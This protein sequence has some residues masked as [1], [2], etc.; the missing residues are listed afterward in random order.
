M[1]AHADAAARR[2]FHLNAVEGALFIAGSSCISAQTVLPALVT[3]LG[4][5]NVAVGAI[6]VIMY[7]GLFLPQLFAARYAQTLPW[8]KPWAIGFGAVQRVLILLMGISLTFAA[9]GGSTGMLATFMI[10]FTLMQVATGICTPGWF[11]LFTKLTPVSR[12]G[13]L[14]GLRTSI[15]GLGGLLC[16]TLL[17][18][19]LSVWPFPWSYAGAFLLASV[20]QG[21]SLILQMGLREEAESPVMPRLGLGAYRRQLTTVLGS[22]PGFRRFL[23]SSVF[24]VLAALPMGFYTVYALRHFGASEAAVGE[25]TLLLVAVQVGSALVNGYVADHH[26]NRV[27][28]LLAAS[29]ML[30]ANIWALVAP[31]LAAF[32]LVFVFAGV[33]LGSDL[34]ARYNMSVE[35]GPVEQRSTYVG[36]MNTVLAPVYLLGLAGG[37]LI[38]RFGYELIFLLGICAALA[39]IVLFVWRVHDPRHHAAAIPV[40]RPEMP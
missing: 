28:V 22:N 31:T 3:R 34:M 33:S 8:K 15:G 13:R 10:L 18:V 20:L 6:G 2:N 36:L 26:G 7:V 25:F 37:W 12:R 23:F 40:T 11:D 30:L 14:T 19:M 17:T 1:P 9:P 21:T 5:D 38:D 35:F 39:A 24:I 29:A 27:V 4:G 32:H 16:G